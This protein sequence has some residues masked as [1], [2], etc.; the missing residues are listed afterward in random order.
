MA[1]NHMQAAGTRTKRQRDHGVGGG[2]EAGLRP[3]FWNIKAHFSDTLPPTR[4]RPRPF[5][6]LINCGQPLECMTL[7]GH[8]HSQEHAEYL[9]NSKGKETNWTNKEAKYLIY[10]FLF[11]FFK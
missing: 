1:E 8:S 3:S 9:M 4:S 2:S 6:T 5:K 7:W 10:S 11:L